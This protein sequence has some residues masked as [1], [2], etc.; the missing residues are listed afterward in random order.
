MIDSITYASICLGV[1]LFGLFLG[2]KIFGL[3][4][5]SWWWVVTPLL[6][7]VALIFGLILLI[8]TIAALFPG[9]NL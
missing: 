8:V 6:V 9:P 1:F 3:I 5:W 2:L 4:D 7:P